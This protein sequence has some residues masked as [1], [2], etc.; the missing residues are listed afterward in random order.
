[1]NFKVFLSI[2]L[3]YISFILKGIPER[4]LILA[5]GSLLTITIIGW[6]KEVRKRLRHIII[7]LVAAHLLMLLVLSALKYRAIEIEPM[8]SRDSGTTAVVMLLEGEPEEFTLPLAVNNAF[9]SLRAYQVPILPFMIFNNKIIYD[10]TR[11]N[12]FKTDTIM[13]QQQLQG[14]LGNSYRLYITYTKKPPYL[15]EGINAAMAEG[16]RK[17]IFAPALI[18]ENESFI[19]IEETLKRINTGKYQIITKSTEAMWNSDA[20]A[21]LYVSKINQAI[22]GRAQNTGIVLLGSNKSSEASVAVQQQEVL[23]REKIKTFL[24]E[25]GY[26]SYQL[27]DAQFNKRSIE[28][29]V[30]ALMEYGVSSIIIVNVGSLY[31]TLEQQKELSRAINSVEAPEGVAIKNLHV[32]AYEPEVIYELLK[33]INLLN[34][35]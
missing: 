3:L 30:D 9:D 6:Q 12:D 11:T 26:I 21:L 32:A 29:S 35:D 31:E 10:S 25:E 4:L 7:S 5:G 23:L 20:I 13:L 33:R 22:T 17:I 8:T 19:S 28:K 1:M 14:Q 2:M 24:I 18:T 16:N 27:Q 15:Q 34:I